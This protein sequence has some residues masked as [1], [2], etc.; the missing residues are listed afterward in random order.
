MLRG[1]L[2]SSLM[3]SQLRRPDTRE[4][5]VVV[6][7]ISAAATLSMSVPFATLLVAALLMTPRRWRAIAV[8]ASLGAPL[9]GGLLQLAFH[10]VGWERLFAV[11]LDVECSSA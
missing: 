11:Y 8:F 3:H 6:R 9:G 10:H 1:A 2:E 5:P 4:F 7:G